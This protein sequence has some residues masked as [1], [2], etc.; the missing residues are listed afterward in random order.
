MAQILPFTFI[1]FIFLDTHAAT[2]KNKR[3]EKGGEEYVFIGLIPGRWT[4]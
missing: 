2:T 4:W 3:A 1:M